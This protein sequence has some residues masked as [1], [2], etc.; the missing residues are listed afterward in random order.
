MKD[1]PVT[2]I[3][4]GAVGRSLAHALVRTGVRL[5]GIYSR[6]GTSARRLAR[7]LRVPLSGP[8]ETMTDVS[9]TIIIAVPDDAIHDVV[10]SIGR[11]TA[12]LRGVVVLH[13][14]GALNGRVLAVLERR[15]ASVGS[16]HP[17][18]TF[19]RGRVTPL[20]G[21]WMA[22]EGDASA[23]AA[24]RRLSRRMGAF[25]VRVAPA[26]KAAY[27]AA[28]VLVSNYIVT[29]AAAA[30]ELHRRAGIPTRVSRRMLTPLMRRTMENIITL[31]PVP[32][33]T[34]PVERGDARTVERHRAALA[35]HRYLALY[36]ILAA[37]TAR[38]ARHKK[39]KR[40]ARRLSHP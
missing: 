17:M 7:N 23:V 39:R 19:P 40:H 32:A 5:R 27:H 35:G 13:T 25:T 3:G 18:Q 10:R 8:L 30:E 21:C 15:G 2:V 22:V 36:D 20:D 26:K 4:A 9:G 6:S 33:L 16:L 28:G 1:A 11:T 37:E 34:G 31:G 38:V 12:S 14:A 24:G 29:L